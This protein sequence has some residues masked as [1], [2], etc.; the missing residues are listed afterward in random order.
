MKKNRNTFLNCFFLS[1]VILLVGV[2]C[3]ENN[4]FKSDCIRGKYIGEYCEG[5]VIKILDKHELGEDWVNIFDN[6]IIYNNSVVASIDTLMVKSTSIN[7]DL[8]SPDSV[9]YFRYRNGGYG[10]KQYNIYEPSASIT[11][12]YVSNQPCQYDIED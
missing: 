1:M 12:T 3:S 4:R 5:V 7:N 11:I 9:F 10:R 8:L 2:G 6:N